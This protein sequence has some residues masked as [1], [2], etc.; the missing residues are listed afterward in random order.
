LVGSEMCIRDS[1]YVVPSLL[2]LVSLYIYRKHYILN[3]E[4]LISVQLKLEEKY[5]KIKSKAV[6][7][8]HEP[9]ISVSL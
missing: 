8:E 9:T 1:I 7:E 2:C 6:R 5:R 3:D 4:M